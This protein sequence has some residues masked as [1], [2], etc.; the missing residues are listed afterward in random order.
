MNQFR[1]Y[2]AAKDSVKNSYFKAR[3]YQTVD[4]VNKMQNKYLTFERKMNIWDVYNYLETLVDQSDPDTDAGNALHDLQ[5]AE[6]IRRDGLPDWMVLVGFLHD[7]GKIMAKWGKDEDGNSLNEQWALVGD[8]FIVG[9]QIPDTIIY[10][11][12]NSENPDM[13]NPTYNSKYGIYTKNCGLDNCRIS[14]GHDEYMYQMLKHNKTS[15]PDEALYLIRFHSL[16]L[17]HRENSYQHL[18]SEKDIKLLPLLRQFNSYDL[19]T[20]KEEIPKLD[21]DYYTKLILKYLFSTELMW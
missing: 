3:K 2:N 21:R 19:Y 8:T 9:C 16:Y 4:F 14:F 12:Y 15:L 18:L 10:P 5:T 1:N 13:S 17:H 20:K 6:A 7:F 11:E